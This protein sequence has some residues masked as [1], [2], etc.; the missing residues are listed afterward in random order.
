MYRFLLLWYWLAKCRAAAIE[1]AHEHDIF[2]TRNFLGE[3]QAGSA[4]RHDE[5]TAL[6]FDP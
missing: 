3:H 5:P 4:D 1:S 2:P 6:T